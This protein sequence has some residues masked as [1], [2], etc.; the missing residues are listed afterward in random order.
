VRQVP[1]AGGRAQGKGAHL[2]HLQVFFF[3]QRRSPRTPSSFT[4]R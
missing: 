1:E 2:A 4:P 3:F